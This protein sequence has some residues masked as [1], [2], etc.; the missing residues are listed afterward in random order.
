[1][2]IYVWVRVSL[3]RFVQ[4]F[5]ELR[6]RISSCS[7]NITSPH[8]LSFFWGSNS[9]SHLGRM[10]YLNFSSRSIRGTRAAAPFLPLQRPLSPLMH[11]CYATHS[12]SFEFIIPSLPPPPPTLFYLGGCGRQGSIISQRNLFWLDGTNLVGKRPPKQRSIGR[13]GRLRS[14]RCGICVTLY[15]VCVAKDRDA[16]RVCT[17][18]VRL[19]LGWCVRWMLAQR[20]FD[21]AREFSEFAVV[22]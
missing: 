11:L 7:W 21:K 2:L 20:W 17:D 1:M 14:G 5:S 16:I 15:D 3:S 6:L 10:L 9:R 8:C 18:W 12:A 19:R 22:H 4:L 13:L